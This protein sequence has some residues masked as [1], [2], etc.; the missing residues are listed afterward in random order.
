MTFRIS[1]HGFETAPA[2][3]SS[4]FPNLLLNGIL[5]HRNRCQW[6]RRCS[7]SDV[8]GRR[9]WSRNHVSDLADVPST[10]RIKT[11]RSQVHFFNRFGTRICRPHVT[12]ISDSGHHRAD[13]DIQ[14]KS[15]LG[16]TSGSPLASKARMSSTMAVTAFSLG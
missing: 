13:R 9:T 10:G 16:S 4:I 5:A 8:E 1:D 12:I 3:P 2:S 11:N 14:A 15:E 7:R 6:K